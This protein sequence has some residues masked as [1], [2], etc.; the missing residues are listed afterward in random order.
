MN[1]EDIA[2]KPIR[3]SRE[4]Y[5]MH[6]LRLIFPYGLNERIGDKFKTDNKYINVAAK[7]SSLPRK[8][9]RANRK[10]NHK[11]VPLLLSQQFLNDLNHVLNT[12]IKGIPNFIRTSISSM[13]KI[14][15][16]NYP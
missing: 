8:H 2:A 10:K 5:W 15:L 6:E 3:T 12:N 9:S 13:K 7:F 11:G 4:T 1:I 14:L 16:K